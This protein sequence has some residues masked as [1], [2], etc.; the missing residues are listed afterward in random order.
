MRTL[1][2]LRITKHHKLYLDAS[3]TD[4]GDVTI[5]NEKANEKAKK[6]ALKNL[7]DQGAVPDSVGQGL[8]NAFVNLRDDAKT[9]GGGEEE[10][11]S[12]DA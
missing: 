5:E 7:N 4:S 8:L 9:K 1:T 11:G 6:R 12:D 10:S 3:G 2:P